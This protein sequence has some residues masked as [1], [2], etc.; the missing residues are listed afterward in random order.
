VPSKA[1]PDPSATAFPPEV[2]KLAVVTCSSGGIGFEIA[3]ALAR[4]GADV[5]LAG[6]RP[7]DGHA[8][9]AKIRPLAPHALVRFEKLDLE[10]LSSV[11]DFAK[12]LIRAERPVDLLI[13]VACTLV[14]LKRQITRDRF[15]LHF[16]SNYLSHFALT[17]R[18][19]PLLRTSKVPRVVLVTS[20]GRHHGEIHLDD[21]QLERSFSPLKAYS[22]SKLAMLLFAQE[23]QRQS[24]TYGWKLVASAA[25]PR[26]IHAAQLANASEVTGSMGWYR[27]ALGLSL[28]RLS[29][30]RPMPESLSSPEMDGHGKF[31]NAKGLTDL[32]GPP[33]PGAIDMR[34]LDPAMARTLWELSTELARVTWPYR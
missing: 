30:E 16:A 17:A 26:G 18:L 7:S 23:L 6:P 33:V 27:R 12:R 22:Q 29:T 1:T 32:I 15:E 8:A 25:Q 28:D 5:I 4:L 21:L 10:S 19:L 3:L 31:G 20:T 2:G 9:L 11:S 34:A 13:N 14:L 24:D